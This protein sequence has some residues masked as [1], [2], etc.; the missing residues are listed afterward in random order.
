VEQSLEGGFS[1]RIMTGSNPGNGIVKGSEESGGSTEAAFRRGGRGFGDRQQWHA[2]VR[3]CGFR[4]QVV[5][6]RQEG[7]GRW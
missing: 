3:V 5:K 1:G 4:Q 2:S 7:N 6:E